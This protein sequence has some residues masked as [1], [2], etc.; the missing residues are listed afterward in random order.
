MMFNMG[1]LWPV[2]PHSLCLCHL[3]GRLIL[4]AEKKVAWLT[5]T[6]M[7]PEYV[8]GAAYLLLFFFSP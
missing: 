6:V 2:N 4:A 3:L 1:A 5:L 8:M 7:T